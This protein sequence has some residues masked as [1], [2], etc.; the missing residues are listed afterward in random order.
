MQTK[1][2]QRLAT[3]RRILRACVKLFLEQGYKK[4]TMAEIIKHSGA[5]S[6]SF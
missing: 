4:T 5:S 6:S 3:K 1:Q 2:S